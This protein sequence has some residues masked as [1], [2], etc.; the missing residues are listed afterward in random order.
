LDNLR[1]MGLSPSIRD[2]LQFNFGIE[3][4]VTKTTNLPIT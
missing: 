3:N 1:I 4:E 2:F